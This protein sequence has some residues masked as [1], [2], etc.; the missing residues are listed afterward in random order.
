MADTNALA[1]RN[2]SLKRAFRL[3]PHANFWLPS[4]QSL[5]IAIRGVRPQG[6]EGPRS[7]AMIASDPHSALA[8]FLRDRV[9]A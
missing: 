3:R 2:Q 9:K 6:C 1:P 4:G 7:D 5:A 8:L